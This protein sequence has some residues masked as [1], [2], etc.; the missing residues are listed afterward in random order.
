MA[1]RQ[2]TS[3]VADRDVFDDPPEG[4]VGVHRGSR[5]WVVR[6]APVVIA[7]LVAALVGLVVWGTVSGQASRLMSLAGGSSS[8]SVA[9]TAA[10]SSSSSAAAS[11]SSASSSATASASSADASSSSATDESSSPSSSSSSASQA[12]NKST[13]VRVVNAT[14]V[15]GYAARKAAVLTE[16]GYTSVVAANPSGST[17]SQTVVWYQNETDE[18]TAQDVASRLGISSV[19]QMSGLSAPIVV[20]LLS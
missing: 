6:I 7:F 4:P 18:A 10:S 17:P 9:S 13:S 1:R 3:G 14:S 20:V 19:K 5:S 15:T 12:V 11:S 2:S 16:A 8:S